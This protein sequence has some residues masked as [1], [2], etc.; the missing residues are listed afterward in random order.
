[1]GKTID[2]LS[3]NY[4]NFLLVG[5]F[6]A[7]ESNTSVK[8]FCDIYE[9]KYLIKEPTCYKNPYN[10]KSVDL[11]YAEN[12]ADPVLKAIEQCKNHPSVRIINNGYK[13]NS[14]FTFNQVSLE[15]IQKELKNINPSKASQSSDIPTKIIRQNLDLF[16]QI[17]HQ[18]MN[19]S[20]DLNKFPS[21]MKLG[22]ITPSF[23]KNDRTNKENCRPT[24]I[25]PNLSKVF[26]KCIYKQLS[27]F[28]EIFIFK[29]KCGFRKGLNAQHC[30]IK[31]IEKWRECIDQGL[32]FGTLFGT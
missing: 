19:Q 4:K 18:E 14:L 3:T 16:A 10:S 25:L 13:T 15:E 27:N 2:F 9:F 17:L 8:D 6:N 11:N 31:L 12:I 22:N 24:S 29:I 5:H 20:L 23:Q 32:E 21:T 26:E 28:F 7:E 1:M 30:L